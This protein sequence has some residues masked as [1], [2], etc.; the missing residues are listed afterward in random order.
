MIKKIKIALV[1]AKLVTFFYFFNLL[2]W[3]RRHCNYVC[4]S[5]GICNLWQ[6][7]CSTYLDSAR[8]QVKKFAKYLQ[9]FNCEPNYF[10]ILLLIALL[11]K[12]IKI[13]SR[14][15]KY[16]ESNKRINQDVFNI[17]YIHKN[18]NFNYIC[19]FIFQ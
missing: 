9:I 6:W 10:C 1:I 19:D 7:K 11:L 3:L 14:M 5:R 4:M 17:Y 16:K 15:L 8:I 13:S 18:N 12:T 2:V